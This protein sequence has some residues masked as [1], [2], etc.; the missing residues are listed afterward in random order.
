MG[1][2]VQLLEES[3]GVVFLWQIRTARIMR[4][5]LVKGCFTRHLDFPMYL[6]GFVEVIGKYFT[7]LKKESGYV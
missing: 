1:I 6:L 2:W 5:R 7:C 4:R 3:D